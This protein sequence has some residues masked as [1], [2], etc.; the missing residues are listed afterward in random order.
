M[1]EDEVKNVRI[2]GYDEKGRG[3]VLILDAEDERVMCYGTLD[4][5]TEEFIGD[6]V[7]DEEYVIDKLAELDWTNVK[8]K[9]KRKKLKTNK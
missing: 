2:V 3:H 8:L 6:Y 4:F 9:T 5:E 1:K 7:I